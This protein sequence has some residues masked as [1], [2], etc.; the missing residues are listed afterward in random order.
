MNEKQGKAV[1]DIKKINNNENEHIGLKIQPAEEIADNP[2]GFFSVDFRNDGVFLKIIPH[3]GSGKRIKFEDIKAYIIDN[4]IENVDFYTLRKEIERIDKEEEIRIADPQ[5]KYSR[6]AELEIKISKDNMKA[7]AAILPPI[8]EGKWLTY[9]DLLSKFTE[10]GIIYGI[11]NEVI[12]N[13]AANRK[14]DG[15]VLVAE[16]DYPINGK[17]AE[18]K[19]Y[20]NKDKKMLPSI[21]ENGKADFKNLNLIENVTK[22]Q[23]L[24]VKIPPE[25]GKEGKNIFGELIEPKHR[26]EINIPAGK[27]VEVSD[28][29]LSSYASI[30][31][32]V[33]FI[34]NKINVFPVFE[35]QGDVG[36]S[37]GNIDFL[38]SVI[39]R[40]NVRGGFKIKAEGDIEIY[41]AVEGAE[42]ISNGNV[43]LHRGIQGRNKGLIN[44]QGDIVVVK[45][46]ENSQLIAGNNVI[47]GGAIMHSN[48]TAGDKVEVEGR[49]G[50]IVGGIVRAGD[51]II[52]KT[53]GSSLATSTVLE[54][55]VDPILKHNYLKEKE[56]KGN[57]E[58]D[59]KKTKQAID[60]LQK[61]DN[62]GRLPASK[63]ITLNKLY[64]TLI[65]LEERLKQIDNYLGT[66]EE[67]IVKINKGKIK[68][69]DKI[70]PGVKVAI[71]SSVMR[72]KDELEN[73]ILF[74]SDEQ[75]KI[76]SFV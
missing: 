57:I 58:S 31:G 25:A 18:I 68:V 34:K 55:G 27:N 43:I 62:V 66:L 15:Y 64:K 5:K 41:G 44:A 30:D 1:N 20:F 45:Y 4:H 74:K 13:L 12:N 33:L 17:N 32:Q 56:K 73:V 75:I 61:L 9:E 7:Y 38:G 51:E 19:Y 70:Y 72:V 8:G 14:Q 59:Y 10:K 53:I 54:V 39:V 29:G 63:K 22:G 3:K 11:K 40:G 42:I 23:L 24:A 69:L 36:T 21:R 28:D 50:L 46:V 47:V 65:H 49:K 60:L 37:T 6:D 48:V 26:R 2:D 67:E 35:V 76:G 52:A 16:G 71:G